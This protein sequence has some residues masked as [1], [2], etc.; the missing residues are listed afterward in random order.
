MGRRCE[1]AV[2]LREVAAAVLRVRAQTCH[3]DPDAPASP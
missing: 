3:G 2:L 1:V